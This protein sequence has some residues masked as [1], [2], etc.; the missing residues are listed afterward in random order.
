MIRVLVFGLALLLVAGAVFFLAGSGERVRTVQTP[1]SG[2]P[3]GLAVA[4]SGED[5]PEEFRVGSF[6]RPE[7]VPRY[8]VLEE[9]QVREEGVT[10]ARLLVD[11]RARG[12]G[13]Y[14]LI[15]RDLKAR[16]ADH[17]AVSIEFTDTE[18]FLEYKGGALI[19]NTIEGSNYLGYFYAPPNEEGYFVRAVD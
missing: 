7:G 15:T 11:T 10:A 9:E 17:D 3:P 14:E 8:Q 18:D 4:T 16:Y 6:R 1:E 13:D 12:E 19:F 5:A 2:P